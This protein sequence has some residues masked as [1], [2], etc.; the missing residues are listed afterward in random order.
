MS[1]PEAISRREGRGGRPWLSDAL[2]PD[3]VRRSLRVAALVGAIPVTIN[4]TVLR[5]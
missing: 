4:Y 3:V 1:P 2:R 5:K